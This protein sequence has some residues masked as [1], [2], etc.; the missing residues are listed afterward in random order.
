MF[1]KKRF[2]T[3]FL[4]FQKKSEIKKQGLNNIAIATVVDAFR[5]YNP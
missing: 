2:D 4:S 3:N 1:F 5:Y